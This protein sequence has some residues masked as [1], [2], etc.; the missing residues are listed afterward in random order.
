[1]PKGPQDAPHPQQLGYLN[2][3]PACIESGGFFSNPKFDTF[4][5]TIG[6]VNQMFRQQPLPGEI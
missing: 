6:K 4:G 5:D 3:I 2:V 1:M